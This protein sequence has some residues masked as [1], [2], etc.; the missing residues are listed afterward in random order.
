MRVLVD[1]ALPASITH[2]AP[3]SITYVR[4]ARGDQPDDGLV[5]HAAEEGFQA[6]V[7]YGSHALLQPS[8]TG[9]AA[10]LGIVLL[11]V[12]AKSPVDAKQYVVR[13]TNKIRHAV[14]KG[15]SSIVNSQGVHPH[16][17]SRV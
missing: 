8:V 1:A 7:F 3:S 6:V 15:I 10:D 14:T 9:P 16:P 17:D 13:S 4:W 5:V 12:D 11:A 2:D